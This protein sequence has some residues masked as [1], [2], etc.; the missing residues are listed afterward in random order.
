MTTPNPPVWVPR[1]VFLRSPKKACLQHEGGILSQLNRR[2]G[3]AARSVPLDCGCR[4]GWV[5][6]CTEPPLSDQALDGWRDAARH[7]LAAGKTPA[8][9]LEVLRALYRRGGDDRAL[10]QELHSLSNGEIA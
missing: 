6:R 2:R 3:S 8:L 9:P 4:D 1:R 10:A 5:C 7:I